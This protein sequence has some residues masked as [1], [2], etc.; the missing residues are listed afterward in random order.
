MAPGLCFL[1]SSYM[2]KDTNMTLSLKRSEA[3]TKE[4]ELVLRS[5]L[6]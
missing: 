1:A 2:I 6:S 3:I 4:V 5:A